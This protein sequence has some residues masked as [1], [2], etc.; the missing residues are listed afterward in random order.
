MTGAIDKTTV[1]KPLS[2]A[3]AR[4]AWMEDRYFKY[5]GCAPDADNPRRMAGN[6]KLPVGAHHAPDA[7]EAESQKARRE[8]EAAVTEVCLDCPV[9][10]LCDAYASSVTPEGRLAEPD[11]VWGGR[12][13]LERHKALIRSRSAAPPAPDRRFHTA[14]KTAVLRAFAVCWDPYEVAAAADRIVRELEGPGSAGMD[15]RTVNWQRSNLTTL[16]GLPHTASRAQ[17]LDAAGSRGLLEGVVVV[18]DDGSVLAVPPPT[19]MPD[20]APAA[21]P[22]AGPVRV[23]LMPSAPVASVA[24]AAP[25]VPYEPVRIPAPRRDRFT[26]I[27]GQLALWEAELELADVHPLFPAAPLEAAA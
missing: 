16:L 17:F 15:L 5:R 9:M 10:V 12:T 7:W 19:R 13:G 11:G 2:S 26:D 8:R 24:L 3:A 4:E 27:V 25:A 22:D 21:R 6:P 14:Q 1:G 18:A 20:R 23:A